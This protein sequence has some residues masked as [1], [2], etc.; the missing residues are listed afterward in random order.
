MPSSVRVG[1]TIDCPDPET[2]AAFWEKFLGYERRPHKPASTYVSIDKPADFVGPPHLTFQRVSEPKAGKSRA[3][4][5]LFV[6]HAL[7]MV[8]E[9][10]ADGAYLVK[11]TE[12]GEWTTRI[13]QDPAGSEFCVIGP[14]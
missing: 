7:P 13:L 2:V 8:D 3:H 1:I 4:L 12:A 6:E 11:V 5:D 14:D 9:M 10:I